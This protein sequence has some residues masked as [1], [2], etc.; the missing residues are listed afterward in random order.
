MTTITR[1][2]QALA[3]VDAGTGP[4]VAAK[5]VGMAYHVLYR[6]LRARKERGVC[7]C[8]GVLLKPGQM[9][10]APVAEAAP[11]QG[12]GAGNLLRDQLKGT[13]TA[14]REEAKRIVLDLTRY[15]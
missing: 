12:A 11:V 4:C 9:V 13:D 15:I 7:P 6:A 8:C 2:Q 14:M 5:Q 3:L 10:R 1:T